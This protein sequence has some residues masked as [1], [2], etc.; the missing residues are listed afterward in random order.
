M[1]LRFIFVGEGSSDAALVNALEELCMT[2]EVEEVS[3]SA[4]D[5]SRI[6]GLRSH[7]VTDKIEAVLHLE[8]DA[9]L[10]FVHRDA[11]SRD[12]TDRRCEINGAVKDAGINVPCVPVVPIQATE[13]WVLLDEEAVRKAAENP[14]GTVDL[15]LP[16]PHRV[17][18][19]NDPK[20]HLKSTLVKASELSGRHLDR[21]KRRFFDQRRF[22][23]ER[24]EIHGPISDVPAWRRLRSDLEQRLTTIRD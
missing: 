1:K 11:D 23:L 24:I 8:P 10:L 20:Q 4:P 13:A 14:N 6:P 3:G 2:C 17:H 19:I 21:F 12:P 16:S 18:E 15:D 22:L 9:D 7:K 5:L